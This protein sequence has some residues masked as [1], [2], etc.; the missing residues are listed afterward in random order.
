MKNGNYKLTQAYVAEK[1]GES[2]GQGKWIKV[3]KTK[4]MT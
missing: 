4:E 2:K 1:Y 3:M